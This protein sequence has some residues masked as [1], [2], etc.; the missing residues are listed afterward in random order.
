[1]TVLQVNQYKHQYYESIPTYG[2]TN[3]PI[4]I[5]MYG[6]YFGNKEDS[7]NKVLYSPTDTE[8]N[9][10]SITSTK[11]SRFRKRPATESDSASTPSQP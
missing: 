2:I 3:Q 7:N 4:Q 5:V 9:N 1:L 6:T 8:D 11:K 10:T